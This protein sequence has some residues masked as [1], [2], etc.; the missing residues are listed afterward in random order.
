MFLYT[1]C[2]ILLQHYAYYLFIY[3]QYTLGILR[4]VVAHSR[5]S[6]F[7]CNKVDGF[8]RNGGHIFFILAGKIGMK[9]EV[10]IFHETNARVRCHVIFFN[11][12][13]SISCNII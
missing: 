7:S 4:V 10:T 11:F 3:P 2:I 8:I 9:I 12:H 5:K 6:N 13:L 1:L